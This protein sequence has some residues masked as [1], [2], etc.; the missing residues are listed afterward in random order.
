M[1]RLFAIESEA[2]SR[3]EYMARSYVECYTAKHASHTITF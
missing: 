3:Y 2:T 1:R